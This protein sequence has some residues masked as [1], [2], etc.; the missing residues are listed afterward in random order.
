MLALVR[1]PFRHAASAS[2]Y[3]AIQPSPPHFQQ[4]WVYPLSLYGTASSF[5]P[6]AR[7]ILS[8]HNDRVFWAFLGLPFLWCRL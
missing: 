7:L 3:R 2:L 4:Q 5:F 6:F 1:F 8:T